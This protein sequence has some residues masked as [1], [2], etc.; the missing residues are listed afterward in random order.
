MI[1]FQ[2]IQSPPQAKRDTTALREW[3]EQCWTLGMRDLVALGEKLGAGKPFFDWEGARTE[4]GEALF[5]A[6][7][8]FDIKLRGGC[9]GA[10]R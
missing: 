8:H 1:N 7:S 5:L 9:E 2:I 3:E 6:K 4:E 10:E